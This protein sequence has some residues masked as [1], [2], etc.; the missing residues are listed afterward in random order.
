M[1]YCSEVVKQCSKF[2]LLHFISS[3]VRTINQKPT[4]Q[5]LCYFFYWN[6]QLSTWIRNDEWLYN[7]PCFL[8]HV[9]A[10]IW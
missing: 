6:G 2:Q 3:G 1:I 7:M 5:K 8:Q 9:V 10:F 4:V